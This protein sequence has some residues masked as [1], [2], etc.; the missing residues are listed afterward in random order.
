[1]KTENRIKILNLLL[2]YEKILTQWKSHGATAEAARMLTLQQVEA[3][4]QIVE[5][6]ACWLHLLSIV[7]SGRNIDSWMARDWPVDFDELLLCVPL[8]KLVDYECRRCTIGSRQQ[9]HSCAHSDT[10]FGRIGVLLQEKNRDALRA[11]LR[12]IR[13]MLAPASQVKWNLQTHRTEPN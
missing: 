8:C 5:D 4:E 11:H 1:M 12:S 10:V 13:E 9:A 3:F 2:P 6:D 7:D